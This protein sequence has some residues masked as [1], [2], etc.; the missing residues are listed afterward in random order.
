MRERE[1]EEGKEGGRGSRHKLV[2]LPVALWVMSRTADRNM[3]AHFV[4]Q[5]FV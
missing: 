2:L 1:R 4:L 3:C 5:T